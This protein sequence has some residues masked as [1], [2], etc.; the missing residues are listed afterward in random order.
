ML[1]M[2]PMIRARA[3]KPHCVRTK[4]FEGELPPHPMGGDTRKATEKNQ[5]RRPHSD[6]SSRSTHAKRIRPAELNIILHPQGAMPKKDSHVNGRAQGT[7]PLTR[8]TY[9]FLSQISF[10]LL[11]CSFL[12]FSCYTFFAFFEEGSI[13]GTETRFP[14]VVCEKLNL[15]S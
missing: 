12:A 13:G 15:P 1:L 7:K 6:F 14:K 4:R 11:F 5:R 9:F 2:R 3:L 10:S 8:R